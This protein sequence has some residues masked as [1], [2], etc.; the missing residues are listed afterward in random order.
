M[1]CLVWSDDTPKYTTDGDWKYT[2][3][4]IFVLILIIVLDGTLPTWVTVYCQ[5]SCKVTLKR[6]PMNAL[7]DTSNHTPW[8][9]S[10][11]FNYWLLHSHPICIL[12]YSCTYYHGCLHFELTLY[13]QPASLY[14]LR[15]ALKNLSSLLTM[16]LSRKPP[17]TF[18]CI[19]LNMLH[20]TLP[21]ALNITLP[22]CITITFQVSSQITPQYSTCMFPSI[23][24]S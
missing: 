24:F 20:K 21:I 11:L 22:A 12:P 19:L 7:I 8:Y 17:N 3:G 10:S 18:T 9:T 23:P 4:H 16:V 14:A 13:L 2:A 6:I 5:V 1:Y 15:Q